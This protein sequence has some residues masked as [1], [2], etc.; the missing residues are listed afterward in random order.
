MFNESVIKGGQFPYPHILLIF[1]R[2]DEGNLMQV[3]ESREIN[4]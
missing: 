1:P 3:K 2:M 4:S